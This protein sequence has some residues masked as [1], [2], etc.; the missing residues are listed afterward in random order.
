MI[1]VTITL[2]YNRRQS[3]KWIAYYACSTQTCHLIY[4]FKSWMHTFAEEQT[5]TTKPNKKKEGFKHVTTH[6]KRRKEHK[7]KL[8]HVLLQKNKNKINENKIL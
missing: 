8:M 2:H 6:T 5:T 3:A 4:A 7:E 1:A